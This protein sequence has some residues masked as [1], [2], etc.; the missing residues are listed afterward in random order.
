M[1][2]KKQTPMMHR[3]LSVRAGSLDTEKRTVDVVWAT[4]TPVKTSNWSIGDYM[5]IL[6][7]EEGHLRKSRLDAG[8]PVLDNHNK[9]DGTKGV[10]GRMTNYAIEGKQATGTLLFSQRNEYTNGVWKDV[11]DGILNTVSCGY[12]VYAYV[13]T[14]PTRSADELPILKAVD[15]EVFE[16]SMAPIPAD[17]NAKTRNEDQELTETTI[18]SID[19][20]Q[21][22]QNKIMA[23][24]TKIEGGAGED[25]NRSAQ[26]KTTP[27]PSPT[28]TPEKVDVEGVRKEAIETERKRSAEIY[29]SCRKANLPEEF[30]TKLVADGTPI[31]Q[32]RKL[33]IDEFTKADP[34]DGQRSI[35]VGVE[36][37]DKRRA[38]ITDA[39]LL[40]AMP[41]AANNTKVITAER[42][43]AARQYRGLTLVEIARESLEKL[44]VNTRGMDKMELVGRS[45]TQSQSDLPVLLEGTNRR[46]L[47]AAYNATADTWRRFCAI[48]SVGDFR[49]YKRLR[50]GSLTNL[51][52]LG[53]G[54][55]FKNKKINDAEF[56]KIGIGTKGNII[57][58]TREMIINDDL[59]GL[60][61][62]TQ[63]LGRAAARTI[64]ADVYSLLLMNSGNGPTMADTKALFHADHGNIGTGSALSV[65]G[66][67]ADRVLMAQQKD[68]NGN[69]YLDIRP[70]VLLVPIG[71]G[72]TAKVLNTSTYD[73]DATNKLQKPNTALGMFSDI[74]DTP[75]L[76]G[77][78][79]YMF[80]D[81]NVEPVFEVAFLDGQQA[82]FM[83]SQQGWRVDGTE[84]KIRL[85]FGVAAIG[86]R[87][88]VKNAGA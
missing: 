72:S 28:P 14:N 50:L 9:W 69:D 16:I 24:E 11:Q 68:P 56:E 83:E 18:T 33:I 71:L 53:E 54:R 45:F 34:N 61:R 42:V 51:D 47:L 81:P 23:D 64:E 39:L 86:Y 35:T 26:S 52:A 55:E 4:D 49:E 46:V 29:D 60:T 75:R 87:G 59:A 58:V 85:D 12:R 7:F 40:R 22:T 2:D 20:N 41:E 44:G 63:M 62:L 36:E 66:L 1:S 77:T 84:W 10:L 21:T 38:A 73:P 67:D 25:Q 6:S 5:E 70:S 74:V 43:E 82:P 17:V 32:A 80:A 65:A 15:W 48:G 31:E 57:A 88:V 8:V 76:T 37:T 78:A 30:A 13:D 79:R 3:N 27:T 19:K